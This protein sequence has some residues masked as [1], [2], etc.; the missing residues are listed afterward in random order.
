MDGRLRSFVIRSVH[1]PQL[2]VA[3]PVLYL[4]LEALLFPHSFAVRDSLLSSAVLFPYN[5]PASVVI[6]FFSFNFI[7]III[8]IKI[9]KIILTFTF[10]V[11]A[12]ISLCHCQCQSIVK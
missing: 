2:P 9:V 11:C 12:R 3:T 7:I 8:I 6:V 4:E 5:T 1:C 10:Y